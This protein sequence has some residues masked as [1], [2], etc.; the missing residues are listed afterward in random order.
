[1][2]RYFTVF[3]TE[4]DRYSIACQKQTTASLCSETVIYTKE[5]D[6]KTQQ[7]CTNTAED[8]LL[9][10]FMYE[11]Q[12]I[13]RLKDKCNS[14]HLICHKAKQKPA[15][16]KQFCE[17]QDPALTFLSRKKRLRIKV[18]IGNWAQQNLSLSHENLRVISVGFSQSSTLE[19]FTRELT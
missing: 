1:M 14:R 16:Q 10:W 17:S 6:E 8:T 12:K 4:G 9:W 5:V 15:P 13:I 18:D 2:P 19:T 7:G 3:Q 11:R